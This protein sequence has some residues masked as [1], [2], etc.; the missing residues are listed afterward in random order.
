[1]KQEEMRREDDRVTFIAEDSAVGYRVLFILLVLLG[2]GIVWLWPGSTEQLIEP[3]SHAG[4]GHLEALALASMV[5]IFGAMVVVIGGYLSDRGRRHQICFDGSQRQVFIEE[6][7]RGFEIDVQ[8]PFQLFSSFEVHQPVDQ[9]RRWELGVMLQNQS[10]WRLKRGR[11]GE[12]LRE[13]AL[14][15]NQQMAFGGRQASP[16]LDA[17]ERVERI[18]DEGSLTLRWTARER[19]ATRIC[20]SAATVLFSLACLLPVVLVFDGDVRALWAALIL[21]VGLFVFPLVMN[22]EARM[23]WPFV[24]GWFAVVIAAV[25]LVG[26]NWAY[27]PLATM[28]IAIFGS[29]CRELIAGLWRGEEHS[30]RIGDKGNIYEDGVLLEAPEG[31]VRAADLDGAVVNITEIR[32]AKMLLVGPGGKERNR[33]RS[34]AQKLSQESEDTREAVEVDSEGVSLFE[35]IWV[36][37]LV[38]EEI[39]GRCQRDQS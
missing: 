21:G 25:W 6:W 5:A 16:D 36:S 27:F 3:W 26:A 15:L 11:D 35:L 12:A 31:P 39:A 20:M 22:R 14:A 10:Y 33:A 24:V 37:L 34:L 38:D 29:S 8:F 4:W 7:W 17:L 9:K 13:E 28:G 23:A 1:M 19:P 32:P 18:E 2:G 30:I